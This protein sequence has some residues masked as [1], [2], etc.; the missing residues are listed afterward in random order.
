MKDADY[1]VKWDGKAQVFVGYSHKAC[2]F[3]QGLTAEEAITA[4]RSAENLVLAVESERKLRK[5][6]DIGQ[7]Q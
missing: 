5:I 4:V 3:S 6:L 7:A 2:C 1:S